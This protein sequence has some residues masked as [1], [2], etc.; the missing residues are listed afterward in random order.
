MAVDQF[1]MMLVMATGVAVSLLIVSR[2]GSHEL[3]CKLAINWYVA[4][5]Q[6]CNHLH[7]NKTTRSIE[8][9]TEN[10]MSTRNKEN[11]N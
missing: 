10:K 2:T 3:S 9:T 8:N 7:S 1:L 4:A 5:V 11:K 6:C